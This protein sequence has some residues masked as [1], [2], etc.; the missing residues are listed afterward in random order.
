MKVRFTYE[1]HG[2]EE[3][4]LKCVINQKDD[5]QKFRRNTGRNDK[6][7]D[8]GQQNISIIAVL[9]GV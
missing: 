7:Y 6:N 4:L 2:G 8:M 5:T 9:K 1:T 3:L